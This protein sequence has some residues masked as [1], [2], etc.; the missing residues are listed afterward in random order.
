MGRH[1]KT[2][3]IADLAQQ[4]SSLAHEDKTQLLR[5][6]PWVGCAPCDL[7]RIG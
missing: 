1:P 6:A 2:F 4:S 5:V 3:T 7:E